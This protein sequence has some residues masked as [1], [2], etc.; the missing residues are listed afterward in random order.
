MNNIS[1]ENISVDKATP[2]N[3]VPRP[4]TR[5]IHEA[6]YSGNKMAALQLEDKSIWDDADV[7]SSVVLKGT[8]MYK[9]VKIETALYSRFRRR[10]TKKCSE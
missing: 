3:D 7:S 2:V 4:R 10:L 8:V 5:L 9:P 1:V 6:T